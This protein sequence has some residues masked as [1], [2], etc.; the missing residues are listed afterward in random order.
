MIEANFLY[1]VDYNYIVL[2][3]VKRG[4]D[5]R[6]SFYRWGEMGKKYYYVSGSARSRN[7]ARSKARKQGI[8][9]QINRGY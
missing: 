6:G 2:M 5:S 7:L 8:A 4:T 3:P 1:F 9:I